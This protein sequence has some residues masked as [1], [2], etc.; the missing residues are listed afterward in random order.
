MRRIDELEL[1]IRDSWGDAVSDFARIDDCNSIICK[2]YRV[3]T[4]MFMIDDD[5]FLKLCIPIL[6]RKYIVPR[7][8]QKRRAKIDSLD[9]CK[10]K[11]DVNLYIKSLIPRMVI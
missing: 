4:L 10:F 11:D 1:W 6:D 8:F 2:F 9:L 3:V 7:P 5:G